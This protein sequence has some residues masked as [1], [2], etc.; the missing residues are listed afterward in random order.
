M[1]NKDHNAASSAWTSFCIIII[2]ISLSVAIV[3]SRL[4]ITYSLCSINVESQLSFWIASVL[5]DV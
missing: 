1:H 2:Y 4:Q 5:I 3:M